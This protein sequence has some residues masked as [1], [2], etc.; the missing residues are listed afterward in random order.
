MNSVYEGRMNELEERTKPNK[1]WFNGADVLMNK[2]YKSKVQKVV[3]KSG[4]I[5][6]VDL[7]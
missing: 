7:R 6:I 5:S 3:Y 1:T 4:S 2:K